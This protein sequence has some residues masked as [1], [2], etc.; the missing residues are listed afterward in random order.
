[1]GGQEMGLYNI[2]S[3]QMMRAAVRKTL[4]SGGRASCRSPAGSGPTGERPAEQQVK[5]LSAFP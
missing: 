3:Q 2:L 5:M 1:M 4:G